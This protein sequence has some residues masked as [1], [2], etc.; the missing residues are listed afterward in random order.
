M[1]MVSADL[2][3][4]QEILGDCVLIGEDGA[5]WSRADLLRHY[6]DAY[7]AL[8]SRSQAV[9][10]F[11]TL[12][13]PGRWTYTA[14]H[15][16]EARYAHGGSFWRF[17][18]QAPGYACT[19]QFE[20][21]VLEGIIPDASSVG[22]T[23]EWERAYVTTSGVPFRF[24]LPRDNERVHAM[25]Y[26]HRR[27]ACVEV[28]ELD[29]MERDWRSIGDYPMTWT[30]GT[31]RG[32]TFEI[33]EIVMTYTQ[34]YSHRGGPYGIPRTFSGTRTYSTTGSTTLYGIPRHIESPDRQ[35]LATMGVYGI[36]RAWG[37]S[38]QSL[39]VLEVVGPEVPDMLEGDT[40]SLIPP[41]MQKYL[42][43]YT[44]AQA[45][46][47]QGEGKQPELS[48]IC[49]QLFERGIAQLRKMPWLTRADVTMQRQPAGEYESRRPA[50][51]RL[52]S[53]YPRI[54]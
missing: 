28:R 20:V 36:P 14:T 31:G 52:P 7:R 18:W 23:Q 27:L 43:F 25:W 3:W 46:S 33:Y 11:V 8:L 48:A 21:Q 51:P 54:Y 24:A 44:L 38:A 1:T 10:R 4:C 49:M 45:W 39:L 19:S 17:T 50:R 53:T 29:D 9:R 47:G 12:D 41:Q 15:E 32:R 13:V 6:C 30:M 37:S 2:N 42:R 35:Y 22:V 26:D 34:A 5:L 16:W 40:P